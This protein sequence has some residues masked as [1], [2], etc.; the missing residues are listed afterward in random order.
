MRAA[1]YANEFDRLDAEGPEPDVYGAY[2][3]QDPDCATVLD[4]DGGLQ[5]KTGE[6]L[7]EYIVQVDGHQNLSE[8]SNQSES[9]N[10][11]DSPCSSSD[12]NPLSEGSRG[13]SRGP[14]RCQ[15]VNN[16]WQ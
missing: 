7:G 5:I 9:D 6:Q 16:P 2:V 10:D 1:L 14:I 3:A 11:S 13:A 4:E 12:R 8:G 15:R